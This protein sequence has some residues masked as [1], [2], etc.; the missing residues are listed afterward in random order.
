MGIQDNESAIHWRAYAKTESHSIIRM[1]VWS[2]GILM[3]IFLLWAIFFP[4]SS[5]VVTPGTFVSQGKNKTIQHTSGGRIQQIF[6][7]EGE[8]VI[9][10]QPVLALD[11]SEGRA[12]LTKLQARH[13]S[14]SALKDR[15]DAERSGGLRGIGARRLK[16]NNALLRGGESRTARVK[17]A[18]FTLRGN[19]GNSFVLNGIVNAAELVK[20]GTIIDPEVENYSGAD[21]LIKSQKEAYLSGRNLLKQKI[22]VLAKKAETL[23]KQK[24]SMQVRAHSQQSLLEMAQREYQRLKPLATA[25]YVARNRLNDRERTALELE[26]TVS[27]LKMDMAGVDTQI[28]EVRIQVRKA[29]AENSNIASKEYTKIIGELAELSDQLVAAKA[30]VTG[31]IVRAPATGRLLRLTATTVGGVVGA[32]DRIGEIVPKDAPLVVEARV[33]P[34]DIDYVKEGQEAKIAVTAFNRRVDDMI[35]GRVVYKSADAAKDE[36]TGEPYFTVRLELVGVVGQGRNRVKDIQSGMQSEVYI[37]TGTR[38][39]MNY[40]VKPM[41]DSFRRAFREQ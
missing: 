20:T 8:T 36:K 32:G 21:E 2:V 40:L 41:S 4:L 6:V 33:I 25:G 12:D 28:A 39:F 37:Q 13:A 23:Q 1:G 26:G 9:K 22:A 11:Q 19:E 35:K 3:V 14:L 17:P 27:A 18:G 10:G 15:L 38:T 34:S 7:E 16:L 24:Q 30:T 5:A 29:R 31:S